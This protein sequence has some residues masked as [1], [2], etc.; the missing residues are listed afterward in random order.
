MRTKKSKLTSPSL[1]SFDS[2]RLLQL[3]YFVIFSTGNWIS[4]TVSGSVWLPFSLE[5]RVRLIGVGTGDIVRP[6]DG[7]IQLGL[8]DEPRKDS[9][10]NRAVD[11]LREKFGDDV[12]QRGR[13][14]KT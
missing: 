9:A 5:R 8:F 14:R 11:A 2:Y 7:P 12:I 10:I 4:V 3:F 13:V 6:G 1:V